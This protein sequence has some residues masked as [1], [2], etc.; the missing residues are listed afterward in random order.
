MLKIISSNEKEEET[1]EK[2]NGRNMFDIN[3]SIV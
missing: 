1:F 3:V 2:F